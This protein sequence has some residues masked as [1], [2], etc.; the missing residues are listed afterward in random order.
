MDTFT[1]NAGDLF[2]IATRIAGFDAKELMLEIARLQRHSKAVR[3]N[4]R[5][6]LRAMQAVRDRYK[7][8]KGTSKEIK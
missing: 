3:A 2:K 5:T 1:T 7:E 6:V 8:L 4:E